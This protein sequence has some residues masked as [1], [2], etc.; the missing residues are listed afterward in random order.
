M[1]KG[2]AG[3]ELGGNGLSSPRRE[4]LMGKCLVGLGGFGLVHEERKPSGRGDR[5]DCKSKKI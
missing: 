1:K 4:M 2:A 3:G 5:G